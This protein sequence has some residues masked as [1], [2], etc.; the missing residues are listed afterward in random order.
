M[1]LSGKLNELVSKMQASKPASNTQATNSSS[2]EKQKEEVS[3]FKKTSLFTDIKNEEAEKSPD[4]IMR[5]L[6][7]NFSEFL[8]VFNP[9]LGEEI[10]AVEPTEQFD[11]SIESEEA[12]KFKKA[13]KN[14]SSGDVFEV[15]GEDSLYIKKASG[16]YEKL[17]ISS[18]TYEKLFSKNFGGGFPN[19][20]NGDN[21]DVTLSE[22]INKLLKNPD[23]KAFLITCFSEDEKGNITF[24]I[25]NSEYSFTLE[26]GK[27][28]S[29]YDETL[30]DTTDSLASDM[31]EL[32]LGSKLYNERVSM[33]NE[34]LALDE[35]IVAEEK[36]NHSEE[37]N[38][39]LDNAIKYAQDNDFSP[40]EVLSYIEY[41]QNGATIQELREAFSPEMYEIMNDFSKEEIS[42]ANIDYVFALVEKEDLQVEMEELALDPYMTWN[43]E[44]NINETNLNSFLFL[45]K[46]GKEV[47]KEAVKQ[48]EEVFKHFDIT[49]SF[50]FN[51]NILAAYLDDN[52]VAQEFINAY[53]DMP[54]EDLY[55]INILTYMQESVKEDAD[56][57]FLIK[58]SQLEF[59]MHP[60]AVI[61]QNLITP[62]NIDEIILL[63]DEMKEITG[64]SSLRRKDLNTLNATTKIFDADTINEHLKKGTINDLFKTSEYVGEIMPNFEHE[65]TVRGNL[66]K[67]EI[68]L[69]LEASATGKDV[70]DL[71]VPTLTS[72]DEAA[73]TIA[74]GGVFEVEG[75]DKIY[76]KTASGETQQL[77]ISKDAYNKLFPTLQRYMSNQGNTGDCYLVSTLNNMMTNPETRGILLNCFSEDE[78]G[79][80]TVDLP[81]GDYM[82]TLE[83][84]KEVSDYED[85]D[86]LSNSSMGMQMLE[87]CYGVYL[88]NGEISE[89]MN[90]VEFFYESIQEEEQ[91]NS[92]TDEQINAVNRYLQI[93]N[94]YED[95][96]A[97]SN[98]NFVY[99]TELLFSDDYSDDLE[100]IVSDFIFPQAD[101]EMINE[102]SSVIRDIY[103]MD[104][105]LDYIMDNVYLDEAKDNIEELQN[106]T[107]GSEIRGSGGFN[108]DVFEAFGVECDTHWF[109]DEENSIYDLLDNPDIKIV[110]GGTYGTSDDYMLN[111]DLN[112]AAAHAYTIYPIKQENGEYLF[113]V[114]NPW[115]ESRTSILT[116]DQ[117]EEYFDCLDY[118]YV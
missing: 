90:D 116:V 102:I 5:E 103:S 110:S 55:S 32:A 8:N 25:P 100:E 112:I 83:N 89:Q 85:A 111:E 9:Q 45:N 46:D 31:I 117:M 58:L 107:Y 81:N 66:I 101:E 47:S 78:N 13:S 75:D 22:N 38:L 14:V 92:Y 20:G 74:L 6:E 76:F 64:S 71:A 77:D 98:I 57:D 69:L 106:D 43:R 113:E 26:Q 115:D 73:D 104:I 4:D 54:V 1:D 36:N 11:T 27:D 96:Y 3:S 15:P 62:E 16:D 52:E 18:E 30:I 7:E 94:Q 87:L 35:Q 28:I 80:I 42:S 67:E 91:T 17:D 65:D 19:S 79:N 2:E 33:C 99:D 105:D 114:I 40:Y 82:F 41:S 88:K 63:Q 68:D 44:N 84:G 95:E 109:Y 48:A 51:P 108:E 118:V 61:E 56:A 12:D 70:G 29:D 10:D 23:S 21:N 50:D 60:R 37:F 97:N 86:L 59:D 53:K 24:N 72:L 49:E 93:C 34:W 39:K